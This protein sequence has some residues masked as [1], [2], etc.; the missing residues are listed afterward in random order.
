[1]AFQREEPDRASPDAKGNEP[2]PRAAGEFDAGVPGIDSRMRIE[3][4]RRVRD[5]QGAIEPCLVDFQGSIAR[6]V[7]LPAIWPGQAN[8]DRLEAETPR[9]EPR[10]ERDSIGCIRG[11]QDVA[12]EV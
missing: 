4:E 11:Q 10:D 7:K 1:P 12:C 9:D 3:L 2:R 8:R 6:V 5:S